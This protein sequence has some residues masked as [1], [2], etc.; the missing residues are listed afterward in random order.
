MDDRS[1]STEQRE[2]LVKKGGRTARYMD[3]SANNGRNET[4]G[5]GNENEMTDSER[6][7][8]QQDKRIDI[9]ERG[10]DDNH[11][12]NRDSNLDSDRDDDYDSDR[13][14]NCESVMC[15]SNNRID[16]NSRPSSIASSLA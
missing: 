14:S 15:R 11:D 5:D 9:D 3:I 16:K 1:C 6:G 13:D 7:Y 2:M 8:R 10:S 4:V 12:S